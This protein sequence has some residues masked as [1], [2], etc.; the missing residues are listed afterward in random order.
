MVSKIVN[1]GHWLVNKSTEV[2]WGSA[3]RRRIS[4]PMCDQDPACN[5]H[6]HTRSRK[7]TIKWVHRATPDLIQHIHSTVTD[8]RC[9]MS[10]S[11]TAPVRN[12]A[13][14]TAWSSSLRYVSATEHPTA[15]QYFKRTEQNL[16][17]ISQEAI[18]HGTLGRTSSRYQ[19]F[20][21]LLW[22]P[23]EAA[24]QRS[25]WDQMPLPI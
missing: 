2:L 3:A 23:S 19:V 6:W 1:E 22:K 7:S 21:K 8:R 5:Q 16:E 9:A 12:R 13:P 4:I 10:H 14:L 18:Y 25:S 17:S 15:E 11:N 20:E 24:S